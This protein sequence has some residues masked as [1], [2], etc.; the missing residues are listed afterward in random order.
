TMKNK[1]IYDRIADTYLGKNN[2]KKNNQRKKKKW[3][4][5]LTVINVLILLTVF[6]LYKFV[7]SNPRG[8]GGAG[9]KSSASVYILSQRYPIKLAY[10]LIPPSLG[11]KNFTFSLPLVD[12]SKFNALR[13]RV[14]GDDRAGFSAVLKVEIKSERN[15]KDSYYLKGIS[16]R[17][18]DFSIG[19]SEFKNIT[20][21]SNIAE[22][23]FIFE[24]WNVSE[25]RGVLYIDNIRFSE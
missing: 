9:D 1:E 14:R 8:E 10:D 18:Q 22:L 3:F 4:I 7:L 5:S 19:L 13:L 25:K 2:N 23:S 6:F 15:E 21:W 11:V 12:A 16:G 24:D 17:W 20:D